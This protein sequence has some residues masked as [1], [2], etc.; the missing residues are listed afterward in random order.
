MRPPETSAPE[1]LPLTEALRRWA[2]DAVPG[3]PLDYERDKF[4][5]YARARGLTNVDWGEALKLWWLEAHARAVQ[6]GALQLPAVS[7]PAPAPEPPPVYDAELHTQIKADIARLFGPAGP[8]RSGMR[9]PQG[10]CRRRGP[11]IPRPEGMELERDPVYLAQM[12]ARKAML[13][14]QAVRLQ[15]QAAGL[16]MTGAA[17]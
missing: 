10:P 12:R 7:K 14:A 5:C 4:L 9:D 15:A 6:R 2:A 1:T 11:S 13:R 3:L 16:E 17:D 8:S